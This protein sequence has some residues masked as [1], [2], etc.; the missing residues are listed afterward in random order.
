[1]TSIG[2]PLSTLVVTPS[3]FALKHCWQPQIC[4]RSCFLRLCQQMFFLFCCKALP[5]YLV[6]SWISAWTTAVGRENIVCWLTVW[7]LFKKNKLSV[8]CF[9]SPLSVW[10]GR[11][12]SEGSLS[13]APLVALNIRTQATAWIVLCSWILGAAIWWCLSTGS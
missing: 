5:V 1:M 3:C 7:W 11:Q 4:H 12:S 6:L 10:W 8:L 2:F 13:L 9:F